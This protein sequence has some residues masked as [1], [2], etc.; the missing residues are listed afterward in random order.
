MKA[1]QADIAKFTETDTQV[2]AISVDSTPALAHWAEHLGISYPMLSDF[3]REVVK[4]Y[5][6]FNEQRN[7]G[8]RATFV[9]DKEGKIQ[10]VEEGNSAIDPSA[11]HQVCA[12][13]PKK[14][15]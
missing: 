4:K 13:L 3:D 12:R 9:I 5:G 2:A 8:R 7:M 1:Y 14:A 11:A 15:S 6:V 10:H